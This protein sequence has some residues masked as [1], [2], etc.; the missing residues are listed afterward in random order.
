MVL[1]SLLRLGARR[2]PMT[3][4]RGKQN[5]YKGRGAKS[6][7]R[8]TRKGG[9]IVMR[10]KIPELVVP[11]LEGFELKPYVSYKAPYVSGKVITAQDIL[12]VAGRPEPS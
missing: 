9:F 3:S 1:V 8:H 5:F 6:T 10:E 7:G 11:S 2:I 12:D 4:K